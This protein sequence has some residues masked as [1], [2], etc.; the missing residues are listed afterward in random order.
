MATL[1][2]MLH[3]TNRLGC[4]HGSKAHWGEKEG[5]KYRGSHC[6]G[7]PELDHQPV[8]AWRRK[9][10]EWVYWIHMYCTLLCLLVS[11]V[12]TQLYSH[13]GYHQPMYY[14]RIAENFWGRKLSRISRFWSHPRKFSLWN[15]GGVVFEGWASSQRVN[16]YWKSLSCLAA[17][18]M[19]QRASA[20]VFSAKFYFPPIRKSFLPR[21]FSAI[22]YHVPP[23]QYFSHLVQCCV[24]LLLHLPWWLITWLT[25]LR[26]LGGELLW[27]L[28]KHWVIILQTG[29]VWRMI[30][31]GVTTWCIRIVVY[32]GQPLMLW[33]KNIW[34]KVKASSHRGSNQRHLTTSPRNPLH[35]LCAG[36]I[37]GLNHTVCALI[38][39]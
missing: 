37:E 23:T 29:G 1:C 25:V 2:V 38:I 21:K 4:R 20:K 14:Y 5:R 17:Q 16:Q 22:R 28:N 3:K 32:C 9:S 13:R 34:R 27:A 19:H 12:T 26:Q 11:A 7:A 10:S 15:F 18:R 31:Y 35:V 24:H 30:K 8:Q 6:Y 36:G 39:L 33:G